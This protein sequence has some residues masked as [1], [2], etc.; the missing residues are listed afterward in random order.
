MKA[1]LTILII[2]LVFCNELHAQKVQGTLKGKVQDSTQLQVLKDATITVYRTKDSVVVASSLSKED[3]DFQVDKL[4]YGEYTYNISFYGY[5]EVEQQFKI[6]AEQPVHDAGKIFLLNKISYLDEV[7]VRTAPVS[8]KGDTTEFTAGAFKTIP[9]ASAEDLLKKLPGVE[10]DRDGTVKTQGEPIT[11]VLVDGKAFFGNDA[12]MAT[13]NLPADVIDKVQVIDALS[14]QSEFNGFDDGQ[15]IKTL[16]IVTKKD[17]RKGAFGKGSVAAGNEGRYAASGNVNYFNGNQQVS[18]FGQSNNVN[19]QSF[20]GDDGGGG[21]GRAGITTTLAA[22]ANYNDLW[23][24]NTKVNGSYFVNRIRTENNRDR[25]RETFVAND[26]SLFRSNINQISTTNINHRL[27]FEI[28]Q[29]FGEQTSILFRPSVSLNEGG[30]NNLSYSRTTKGRAL[31]LNNVASTVGSESFGYNTNNSLLLRHRFKKQGRSFSVNLTHA[32]NSNDADG[33]NYSISSSSS[34]GNDTIN[35]VSMNNRGGNSFGS[36]L[37][38][39]ERISSKSQLELNY[40]YNF[41]ES[42]SDQQTFRLNRFTNKHDVEV[43]NLTNKF[44]N[45]NQTHRG[46][47]NYRVQMSRMLSYTVGFAVQNANLVSN[48]ISKERYQSYSFNNYFPTASLQYRKGRTLNLRFNY[49]GSTRQPN[50]NQLQDVVDNANVLNIRSG[51]PLLRQEFHNNMVL[52]FTTYSTARLS[53]FGVNLN[54]NMISNKISNTNTINTTG[55]TIIVD[56]FKLGPGAQFS[57]PQ[58]LNGAYNLNGNINYSFPLKNPKSTISLN[59]RFSHGRDVNLVNSTETFI[60]N[61]TIGQT[62]RL[63]MNL[64][65]RFDLN[66]ASTSTFNFVRYSLQAERNGDFFQQQLSVEPTYVT[67]DGWLASVDFDYLLNRGQSAGFNQGVPLVN[68]AIAKTFL[69]A[70]RGE[71]RLSVF[72][73][74]NMNQSLTRNVEQNFIEDVRTQVLTR[75]FLLSFTYNLRRFS[76]GGGGRPSMGGRRNTVGQ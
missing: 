51:N 62:V 10:V 73:L 55:D 21:R 2:G 38:F 67:K 31:E 27:N 70:K 59:T 71:L 63:T 6:D 36:N 14:E 65:E 4:P 20:Q 56:G 12:K 16:N 66:F 17:K 45:S 1:F 60:N 30:N 28:D 26:S 52:N 8:I 57:K 58:N 49:R 39:T 9:N 11:R 22:G 34:R 25:F 47:V 37:S 13:R 75:Y 35:Q 3:G 46:A 5:A 61:Y 64:K 41:N 53:S 44:E 23:S 33:T 18:V 40:N 68:M 48:N 24:K 76:G 54:A 19:N 7:I 29:R 69:K 15:R 43:N 72:D 50:I 32:A 74:L 42:F